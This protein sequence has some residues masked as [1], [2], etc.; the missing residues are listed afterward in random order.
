[1]STVFDVTSPE[2]RALLAQV[3]HSIDLV[4]IVQSKRQNQAAF[5]RPYVPGEIDPAEFKGRFDEAEVSRRGIMRVEL[6]D[7]GCMVKRLILPEGTEPP[8]SEARRASCAQ[9]VHRTIVALLT[10][11]Q[12]V[13]LCVCGKCDAVS[14]G[15]HEEPL[16]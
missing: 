9:M 5:H 8:Y 1:M 10:T 3:V 15:P 12:P 4:A 13:R 2:G 11:G 6:R 14:W 7:D 16:N